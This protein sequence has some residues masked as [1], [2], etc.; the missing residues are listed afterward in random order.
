MIVAR[1]QT[2]VQLTEDLVAALDAAAVRRGV[3]RSALI[4]AAVT[5]FLADDGEDATTRA[6][7]EGYRRFPPGPPDEW[8]RVEALGER[9]TLELL[10]RLDAEEQAAGVEPW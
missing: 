8:G 4:R 5:A 9:A 7:V 10:Q 1:T 2:I 3:S 6:I